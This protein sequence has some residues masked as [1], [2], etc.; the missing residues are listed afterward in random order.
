MLLGT[1]NTNFKKII[2]LLIDYHYQG[3]IIFQAFRDDEGVKIFK[4]Q[5]SWFIKNFVK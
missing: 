4:N 3:L 2:D 1:G 5:L